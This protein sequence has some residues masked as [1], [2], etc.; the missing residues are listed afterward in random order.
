MATEALQYLQQKLNEAESAE[1]IQKIE[2]LS[3]IFNTIC[4]NNYLTIINSAVLNSAVRNKLIQ[5]SKNE[6]FG[7][8]LANHYMNELFGEQLPHNN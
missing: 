8:D 4:L 1:Y 3:E 6:A 5:L 7:K 2:L